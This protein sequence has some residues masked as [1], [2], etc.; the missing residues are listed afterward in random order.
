MRIYCS[1]LIETTGAEVGMRIWGGA[2]VER[3]IGQVKCY[4]SNVCQDLIVVRTFSHAF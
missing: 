4:N 1:G 3:G 2:D